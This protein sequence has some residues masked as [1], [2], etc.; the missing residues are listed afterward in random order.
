ML[1]SSIFIFLIT[2]L[3]GILKADES[4]TVRVAAISFEPVK[5]DLKRNVATLESWFRQAADGGAQIAVAPEGCLDGY[6]VNEIIAS[7]VPAE[8]MRDVAVPIESPTINHFRELAKELGI[9]LVFGF[10]ELRGDDVFNS[11]LFIDNQGEIRGRY[12]K[13]QF[14]EGYDERWWFNRIGQQ[15]RAFDTPY[16][17]CGVLICNDRWNPLLAKAL[18][19]DGAQFLVIPAFGS[20]SKQ[21]D[22]A[23]LDRARETSLPIVE[24]NVGVSL[25]I[26]ENRLAA[27]DRHREGITFADMRIPS[28]RPIDVDRRDAVE[29]E[30]LAWR[31]KEMPLRL[32]E[33][34]G[35]TDPRGPARERDVVTLETSRLKVTIGN[36]KSWPVEAPIH[37]AGYNGI[38]AMESIDH[39]ESPFVPAYAGMNLEHYFD[40]I[41]R[42]EREVFFEPRYATMQLRKLNSNAVELYQPPTPVF[43]VESWTRFEVT[44][45]NHIDFSFRC[46]PHRDDYAGDFL[47]IFWASYI[48]GP[49]DKSL[50]FID[51]EADLE[52]PMWRQLCTQLHNRDSTVRAVNDEV[53]LTFANDE[54]LFANESPLKYSVPLF[55]GRFRNMVLIYVFQPNPH[56]RFTHSPSGG[57]QTKAGDDTNPAWDFQLII[58]DPRAQQEY[59]LHGRLIYKK[60]LGRDDVLDE[61]RRYLAQRDE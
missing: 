27:V 45:P 10:A 15:V 30:F 44:D 32:A 52:K 21:Q 34:V 50:Y 53:K 9:C 14:H 29:A 7:Q 25:V 24:A 19:S 38:F 1:R 61:A 13:M 5:L 57:G 56:L 28:A 35:E 20:T 39:P 58:P 49:L 26:S 36:N 46:K 54:A 12:N 51:G 16:G 40:A 6:I 8:R 47:G 48:N 2:A 42:T 18:A 43:R 55:Y 60:W 3:V 22:Q 23:V 33:F 59:D 11:A 4:S 17:R 41:P 37:R 31:R